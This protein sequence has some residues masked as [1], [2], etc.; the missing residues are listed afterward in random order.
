MIRQISAADVPAV[1]DAF[2]WL[3]E[4]PG[5]KPALWNPDAAAE[6][7]QVLCE[8][9]TATVF[10]AEWE[11]A[12]AGFC[13]VYLDL[14]SVRMGQRSWLNDLAVDPDHR[15]HGVGS[16]LLAAAKDWAREHGATHLLLDS[17][18]KRVDAHRFYVR[19]EPDLQASCFGWLL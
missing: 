18:V 17:S 2:A 14:I 6:R 19:E 3:F 11:H 10:V 8:S 13:T 5:S 7:L 1:V 12:V 16:Q 15:S 9:A 4:P